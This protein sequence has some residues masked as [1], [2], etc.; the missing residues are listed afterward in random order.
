MQ[1]LRQEVK[2]QLLHSQALPS[3]GGGQQQDLV[4]Q[5][6]REQLAMEGRLLQQSSPP[7]LAPPPLQLIIQNSATSNATQKVVNAAPAPAPPPPPP[8]PKIWTF[9]DAYCGV[10]DFLQSPLNKLFL[11]SSVGMVLWIWH[12]HSR[13]KW[14]M[15]EMQRRIDAN[16][17]LRLVQQVFGSPPASEGRSISS[18]A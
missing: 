8:L 13:H 16:P 14:R 15:G 10:L 3:S 12:G 4:R 2:Q 9:R 17:F 11:F 1:V 6:V 7:S 18:R 5:Q